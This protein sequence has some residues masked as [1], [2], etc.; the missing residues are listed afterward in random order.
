MGHQPASVF[1][2]LC[3]VLIKLCAAAPPFQQYAIPQTNYSVIWKADA[4]CEG[5]LAVVDTSSAAAPLLQTSCAS[6]FLGVGIGVLSGPP[7]SSQGGYTL[8]EVIYG[9]TSTVSVTSIVASAQNVSVSGVIG[10]NN[11]TFALTF[12]PG[13]SLSQVA[14]GLFVSSSGSLANRVFLNLVSNNKESIVG[15]GSQYTVWDLKGSQVRFVKYI[16]IIPALIS[17]EY[18]A[19]L[20]LKQ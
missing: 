14:M 8:A 3:T 17:I 5:T 12:S 18:L 6:A 2:L 15:L 7:V 19:V 13:P 10:A 1:V 9:R 11:A 20:S 16:F 4:A